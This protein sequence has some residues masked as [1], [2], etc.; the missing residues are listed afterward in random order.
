MASHWR[1]RRLLV[2]RTP[3]SAR[4][5]R[6]DRYVDR[7]SVDPSTVQAVLHRRDRR[8]SVYGHYLVYAKPKVCAPGAACAR[9]LP[10]RS[11]KSALWAASI[12]IAVAAS[13]DYLAPL[14]LGA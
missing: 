7:Q 9:P 13:F 3:A 6:R 4:F 12:L 1:D 8:A 5:A 2:R 11:L 14:L 10:K